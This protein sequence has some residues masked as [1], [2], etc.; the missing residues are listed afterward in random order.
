MNKHSASLMTLLAC[1]L[2]A[3]LYAA[4]KDSPDCTDHPLLPRLPGH[5]IVAC[6]VSDAS[7]DMETVKGQPAETMHV[8]GKSLAIA[9]GAQPELKAKPSGP[10]ILS[11]FEQAVKRHGATRVGMVNDTIPV[12]KLA[13]G[14]KEIWVAVMADA[15]GGGYAYRIIEKEAMTQT[16]KPEA[17]D[18]LGCQKYVSALLTPIA[19]YE[20]CGC[21]E[22][23]GSSRDVKVGE[24]KAAATIRIQ[25][26]MTQL[27][28]CPQDERAAKNEAA[29]R[30]S[31]END[32]RKQGGTLI[33]QTVKAPKID[34]YKLTKG[35]KD[36]WIEVWLEKNG[37]YNYAITR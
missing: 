36:T 33:G 13:D 2:S 22:Q 9:Y 4:Q 17:A 30:R 3:N 14:G 32:I 35:G 19:G 23:K 1:L 21:G 10:Q 31:L 24:G 28:Y 8:E 29:I 26:S 37:N 15:T 7:F 25:G 34:V 27:S 18:T 5:Y 6:G 20:V 12:Y 11:S 16:K